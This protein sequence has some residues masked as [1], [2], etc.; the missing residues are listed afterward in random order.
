MLES[1]RDQCTEQ[2]KQVGRKNIVELTGSFSRPPVGTKASVTVPYGNPNILTWQPETITFSGTIVAN[3]PW[4]GADEICM[5]AGDG[6]QFIRRIKLAR[7]LDL[8]TVDP[9]GEVTSITNTPPSD[10]VAN[11]EWSIRGSKG[12]IYV[13]TLSGSKWACSCPAG[14]HGRICKHIKAQQAE[15]VA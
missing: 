12:D 2:V 1:G 11:R 13:V 3:L 8:K 9:T 4:A 10:L 7:I 6:S 5:T 14:Q 15:T